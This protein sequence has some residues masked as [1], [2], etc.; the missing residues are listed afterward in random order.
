MKRLLF[1]LIALAAGI[2]SY[3]QDAIESEPIV[4]NF[5]GD[6]AYVIIPQDITDVDYD[7][8]GADVT[9]NSYT[10]DTEYTYRVSGES[11]N[12]SLVINGNYKLTLELAGVNLTNPNGGA[13]IDVECGKRTDLVL[14]EGTTNTLMDSEWGPQKST[15]YFKGHAD[16]KGGGLLNITSV[17]GHAICAKEEIELK[18]SLGT[19][20]VLGAV[21]DGIHCGRGK[22]NTPDHNYFQMDGGTVNITNVGSDGIDADDYG[23]IIINGGSLSVNVSNTKSDGVKADNNLEINGGYI[24][25]NISGVNSDGL[26]ANNNITVNDGNINIVV[27]GNGSKGIKAKRETDET[28]ATVLNGGYLNVNSGKI[29]IYVTGEPYLKDDGTTSN[30]MD[31]SVDADMTQSGGDIHLVAMGPGMKA[32]NVKGEYTKTGGTMTVKQGPWLLI[33]DDY[34][35]DMTCFIRVYRNGQPLSNYSNVS[36]G[37]FIGTECMGLAEFDNTNYGYIRVYYDCTDDDPVYFK[38]YDN[39][40][41]TEFDL[42]ADREVLFDNQGLEGMPSEPIRLDYEDDSFLLGDVNMDGVVDVSDITAISYHIFGSTP[43]VFNYN[44]ADVNTDGSIDVSDITAISYMI[45]AQ[46]AKIRINQHEPQ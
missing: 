44:A 12:G 22:I 26:S 32:Y 30:C 19:I 13:A 6:N 39:A 31:I 10:T 1:I 40:T 2:N 33:Q 11:S 38:L 8:S 37:A 46:D 4:I 28:E 3:A 24:N 43:A 16:F 27:T 36:V 14:V 9:I 23:N 7:I 5:V 35:Y 15:L 45:F 21:K 29:D 17:Y 34:E 42:T 41:G 25:I 18:S 20:N